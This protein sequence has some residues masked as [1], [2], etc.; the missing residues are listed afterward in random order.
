MTSLHHKHLKQMDNLLEVLFKCQ[1]LPEKDVIFICEKA[2]EV[3]Q[4]ESNVQNVPCPVTICGD[5]HGQF[6]DLMELFQIGGK[7]PDT[8]YLF[9]GDY[10]D[11]GYHSVEVVTLLIALKVVNHAFIFLVDDEWFKQRGDFIFRC[12]IRRGSQFF[13]A[14]MNRAKQPKFTDSTTNAC[15]NTALRRFGKH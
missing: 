1:I 8:N 4:E 10:V 2:K 15:K 5:V 9:M 12:D 3:L 11:R 13:A 6:F 7:L 14:I